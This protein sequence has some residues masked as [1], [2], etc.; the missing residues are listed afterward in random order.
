VRPARPDSYEYLFHSLGEPRFWIPLCSYRPG[1]GGLPTLARERAIGVVYR[2]ETELQ[3][4]Y[5]IADL[6]DQFDG[7]YHFD[8]TRAV[9]PLEHGALWL[10][11]EP[12]ESYPTGE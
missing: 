2:P 10:E 9:Q 4:H 3:S 11:G 7:V 6:L 1:L 5:F 12:P 8:V